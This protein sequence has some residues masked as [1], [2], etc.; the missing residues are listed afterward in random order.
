MNN[1]K[2]WLNK[3]FIYIFNLFE[4]SLYNVRLKILFYKLCIANCKPV[5]TQIFYRILWPALSG[6]FVK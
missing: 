6:L 4:K 2:I 1:T 5:V 3:Q